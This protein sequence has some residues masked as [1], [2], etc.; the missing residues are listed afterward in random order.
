MIFQ[1]THYGSLSAYDIS[2]DIFLLGKCTCDI[3]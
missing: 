2:T 1:M 3:K